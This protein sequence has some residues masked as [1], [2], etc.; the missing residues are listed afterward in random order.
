MKKNYFLFALLLMFVFVGTTLAQNTEGAA[1]MEIMSGESIV[2]DAS[3][4]T[5]AEKNLS[6]KTPEIP[7]SILKPVEK[8]SNLEWGDNIITLKKVERIK[9]NLKNDAVSLSRNMLI[10]IILV[11]VGIIFSVLPI[12]WIIG[13]ILVIVGLVLIL[14][15]LL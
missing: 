3:Q 14:L 12:L 15:E 10:G 1:R 4:K 6:A 9:K 11:A 13:V 7:V 2:N 5:Y 8:S